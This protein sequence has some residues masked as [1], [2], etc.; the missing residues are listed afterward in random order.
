MVQVV[1][2]KALKNLL[3]QFQTSKE[4]NYLRF[5]K[6]ENR[7]EEAFLFVDLIQNWDKVIGK[8]FAKFTIPLK[9]Q[10]SCLIILCSH[11]AL[12]EQLKAMQWN[13]KKKID[14][15]YPKLRGEYEKLGFKTNAELF[16]KGKIQAQIKQATP[17]NSPPLHPQ[18]PE[19]KALMSKAKEISEEI[20]DEEMKKS[21]ESLFV[22]SNKNKDFHP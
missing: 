20:S 9:I 10:D 4:K 6:E 16:K 1:K 15:A 14:K 18:S 22:Q 7:K 19:Y 17:K 21:F 8:S 12:S 3:K 13:I 2:M 5:S 11:P